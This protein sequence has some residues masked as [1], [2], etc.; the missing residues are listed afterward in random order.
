MQKPGL[1]NAREMSAADFKQHFE[2][3][4][5]M[6][7]YRHYQQKHPDA[8][9]QEAGAFALRHWQQ[10]KDTALDLLATVEADRDARNA[11]P[12]N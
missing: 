10:W 11:A 7:A 8:T 9:Q 3:V 6:L 2:K 4:C 12:W 1:P 5:R